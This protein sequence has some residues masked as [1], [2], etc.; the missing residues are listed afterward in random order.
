MT[1]AETY[2]RIAE[3]WY[4]DHQ[5][6]DWWVAGT[7][8]FIAKLQPKSLVLDAGC[9]AGN[10][11]AYLLQ[12]GLRVL[13]IDASEGMIAIAKREVPDGMFHTLAFEDVRQLEASFDGIFMQASLLHVPKVEVAKTIQQLSG[14]LRL[15]GYFYI[16][17]KE[18]KPHGPEEEIKIEDYYGYAFERFFSYFTQHE[19]ESYLQSAGFDTVYSTVNLS[20]KTNWIQ[21]VGKKRA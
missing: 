7:E 2:N 16:A 18:Q 4:K 1:I 11:S 5:Q 8:A 3:D 14:V 20:G 17:V 19:V 21:V 15:G 12:H 13:G 9:G 6:D 10:K